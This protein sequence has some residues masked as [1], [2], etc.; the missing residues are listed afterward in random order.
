MPR[1][2]RQTRREQHPSHPLGRECLIEEL[3]EL[4][5]PLNARLGY[6]REKLVA[7]IRKSM[8]RQSVVVLAEGVFE[9]LDDRGTTGPKV[10]FRY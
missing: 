5:E 8:R 4:L 6:L 9:P 2:I 10:S 1:L 3:E 7:V